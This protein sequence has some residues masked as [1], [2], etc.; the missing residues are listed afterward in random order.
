MSTGCLTTCWQIEL[1]SK[2][3]KGNWRLPEEFHTHPTLGGVL[4]GISAV[5]CPQLALL[6][7]QKCWDTVLRE[8]LMFLQNLQ[9]ELIALS[10]QINLLQIFVE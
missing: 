6:P 10:F 5:L 3:K 1:Q 4:C 8:T 9:V 7:H 2:K